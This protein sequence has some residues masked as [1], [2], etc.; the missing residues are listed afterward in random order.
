M[1]LPKS[2]SQVKSRSGNTYKDV[3]KPTSWTWS[4]TYLKMYCC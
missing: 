3:L 1:S 4:A 2:V